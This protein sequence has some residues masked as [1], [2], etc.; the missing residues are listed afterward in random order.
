M[1]ELT[2]EEWVAKY[3]TRDYSLIK[4][5]MIKEARDWLLILKDIEAGKMTLARA[6]ER[7]ESQIIE[8]ELEFVSLGGDID[9]L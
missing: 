8:T 2:D 7:A 3:G 4:G 6:I 9:A 1:S 5:A